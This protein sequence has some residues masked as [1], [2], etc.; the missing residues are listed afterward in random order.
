MP[1]RTMG[2]D[3][4]VWAFGIAIWIGDALL[5]AHRG[6]PGWVV[7]LVVAV[8]VGWVLVAAACV[9]RS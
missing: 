1:R 3:S 9:W 5:L 4:V 7:G 8:A 6:A 2:T